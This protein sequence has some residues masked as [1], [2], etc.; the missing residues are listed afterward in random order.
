MY[1][2]PIFVDAVFQYMSLPCCII[3]RQGTKCNGNVLTCEVGIPFCNS[4]DPHPTSKQSWNQSLW[5]MLLY[6]HAAFLNF[7]LYIPM[8]DWNITHLSIIFYSI[9]WIWLTWEGMK[10]WSWGEMAMSLVLFMGKWYLLMILA[11]WTHC[12]L[13]RVNWVVS[14]D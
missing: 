14:L 9:K 6:I 3:C 8:G 1:M 12:L 5:T 10:A 11:N 2:W 13:F 7:F 4:W